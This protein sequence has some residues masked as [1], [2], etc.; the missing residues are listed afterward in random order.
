VTVGRRNAE[1]HF[2]GLPVSGGLAVA[3]VCRFMAAAHNQVPTYRVEGAEAIVREQGRLHQAVRDVVR[4]LESLRR[5]VADRV[6]AAEAEIFVAQK[7][8]LG[9]AALAREMDHAVVQGANAE[10]AV[11][12]TLD[13]YESRLVRVDN[14]YLKE[15]ASDIGELKR[16]VLGVLGATM[17]AFTC[18]GEEH[19][20]RG[21]ERIVVTQELT[22]ALTLELDTHEVLGIVTERGGPTSHAAILARALGIPAVSGIPDVHQFVTCGTEVLVDGDRGEVVVWPTEETVSH[23]TVSRPPAAARQ[24]SV[25]APV[26]GLRVMANIN[27]AG[28]AAEAC[29]MEAEGIGLYRTEFEFFAAG[30]V[31]SEDEQAARYAAVVDAMGGRPVYI[32]LLDL[33]GDKPSPLFRFPREDNPALG[34]RGARFLLAEPELLRAQARALA[35]ASERGP[36]RVMYPMIVDAEQFLTLRRRFDEAVAD[37][38]RGRLQHGAMLEVPS[39]VLQARELCEA[40]EFVSIGSN[41]LVQY[42]FAVDRSNDRVAYDYTPDRP[43]FWRLLGDVVRAAAGR[44][45]SVCG[46][47]AA[48]PRYVAHLMA[49]GIEAVSVSARHIPTVRR[50][51]AEALALTRKETS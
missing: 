3:R 42:L 25:V 5:T 1:M 17:P 21:R 15:R 44:P 22:P 48:D 31:L 40:G 20:Q 7:M 11:L 49:A 10:T 37:L 34:L 39:A 33:G 12:A 26:E 50:L 46:E 38:P 36:I 30:R 8:I 2:K 45:V 41:D 19:C 18:A 9:D 43:V 23:T 47:M 6:G 24:A 35:R 32:R 29:R 27:L 51:A 16:R 28:E 14:Q 4:H 13:A